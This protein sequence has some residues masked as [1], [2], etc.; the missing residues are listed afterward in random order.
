MR[1]AV[2]SAGAL[3]GGAGT[4][5]R[6]AGGRIASR[7]WYRLGGA[8]RAGSDRGA[9]CER[10]R[11]RRPPRRWAWQGVQ[12]AGLAPCGRCARGRDIAS[13]QIPTGYWLTARGSK[14]LRAQ[15][16]AGRRLH[17]SGSRRS[18][19]R[20]SSRSTSRRISSSMILV[21]AHLDDSPRRCA[22]S[23]QRTID[24]VLQSLL[25][26]VGLGRCQAV[27]VLGPVLESSRSRLIDERHVRGP[28]LQ[29]RAIERR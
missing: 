23:T 16:T 12:G 6:A 7:G 25:L 5:A 19:S 4:A 15:P 13:R 1:S 27:D 29:Q 18:S 14:Q 11:A 10:R 3:T 17:A 26:G 20:S 21:V 24:R 22:V 28:H 2:S 8:R 9:S